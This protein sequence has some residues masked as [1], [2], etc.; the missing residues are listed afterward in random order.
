MIINHV[1]FDDIETK[2]SSSPHIFL[3]SSTISSGNSI[4]YNDVATGSS[5]SS[6]TGVDRC[7]IRPATPHIFLSYAKQVTPSTMIQQS[8]QFKEKPMKPT[9]IPLPDMGI[10]RMRKKH[11]DPSNEVNDEIMSTQAGQETSECPKNKSIDWTDFSNEF[12]QQ[13]KKYMTEQHGLRDEDVDKI[14]TAM[15]QAVMESVFRSIQ[16]NEDNDTSLSKTTRNQYFTKYAT[17]IDK[18]FS[19]D[20]DNSNFSNESLHQLYKD[21]EE[22]LLFLRSALK[23]LILAE[24]PNEPTGKA[25]QPVELPC[26]DNHFNQK[27][28]KIPQGEIPQIIEF[29]IEDIGHQNPV[30]SEDASDLTPSLGDFMDYDNLLPVHH[31]TNLLGNFNNQDPPVK[32]FHY[33]SIEYPDLKPGEVCH[34]HA[35]SLE[36]FIY[37]NDVQTLMR[38]KYSGK[39]SLETNLPDGP[40]LFRFEN[41]DVYVGEFSNG[42]MHGQG[43]FYTRRN[44]KLLKL[45]GQFQHNDFLGDSSLTRRRINMTHC[46]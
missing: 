36:F 18:S 33:T 39:I 9:Q 21:Q 28:Q 27:R 30:L 46:G 15:T 3:D 11:E 7:I 40:G 19:N 17:F 31:S 8:K 5:S 2:G 43:C 41:R 25:P 6:S 16:Q 35:R 24:K 10:N 29:Q 22:E 34:Q 12:E 14:T 32:K 26:D 44:R 42:M 13:C 20:V 37:L 23:H 45:C 1:L 38:G 4:Q